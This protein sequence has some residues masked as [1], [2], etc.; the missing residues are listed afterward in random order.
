MNKWGRDIYIKYSSL[1]ESRGR[2]MSK[3]IIARQY[4]N[5]FRN[6]K[7]QLI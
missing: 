7:F 4:Q 2:M 3:Y 1:Q 5:I 6:F